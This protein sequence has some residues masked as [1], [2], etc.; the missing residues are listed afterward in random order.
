MSSKKRFTLN[1]QYWDDPIEI[2]VYSSYYQFALKKVK[3]I[4]NKMDI[5]PAK[6][7]LTTIEEV[8]R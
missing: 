4:L 7:S 8:R 1:I 2:I 5:S 3:T 6:I